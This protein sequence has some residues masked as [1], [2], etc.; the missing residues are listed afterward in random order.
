M[1]VTR[2]SWRRSIIIL[3]SLTFGIMTM[4][5][6]PAQIFPDVI[7]LPNGFQPEGIAIGRGTTFYVGS[8]PTGAVYRGDLRTGEGAVLVAGAPG[9]AAIG[10]AVDQRDRLFVAGGPT[11]K[12]FVYAPDGSL[13][14]SYQLASGP[15]GTRI[16]A[17]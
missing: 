12:A 3:L 14:G 11:G 13:L 4:G 17:L 16:N 15:G 1:F 9:R 5:A 7:S 8:I 10:V 2:T 6:A